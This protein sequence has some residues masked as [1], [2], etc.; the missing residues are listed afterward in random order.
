[1]MRR[2]FAA[3]FLCLALVTAAFIFCR[4]AQNGTAS[5]GESD[6]VT[7]AVAP[8]VVPSYPAQTETQKQET[9]GRLGEK[10]RSF[11]HALEFSALGFCLSAALWLWPPYPLCRPLVFLASFPA[12]V[13]YALIDEIH[14]LFVPGRAFEWK[15][16]GLDALGAAAG[17]LLCVALFALAGTVGRLRSGS[18][19]DRR[20]GKEN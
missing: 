9:V 14:Q 2:V 19:K 17:C 10:V 20:R 8:V 3:V 13:L 11:A 6:R 16:V 5:S 1:M 12:S 18:G 15:D 7:Q 4:S